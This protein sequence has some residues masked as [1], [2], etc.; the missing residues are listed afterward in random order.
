MKR[1]L[2]NAIREGVSRGI[3]DAI[4]KA[5]QEAVEPKAT[6][7]TGKALEFIDKK[8]GGSLQS[9]RK[10]SS[11]LGAA[12]SALEKSMQGYAEKMSQTTKICPECGRPSSADQTHCPE[13]G[14]KLPEET[15]AQ[16]AQCPACG[17]QN[18][19]R[20]KFC[21]D[22]GTKL[23]ATVREEEQQARR[24]EEELAKWEQLLP[25]FPKWSCGGSELN[26][27]EYDHAVIFS[28]SFSKNNAAAQRAVLEYRELLLEQGFRPAG[29][30][31]SEGQLYK[32]VGALCCH[33]DTE[34]CFEG[35]ADRP[36]IGF[37]YSEP[38]GG[39]HYTKPEP[40]KPANLKDL[41]RR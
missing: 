25:H 9:A 27:E 4:E 11:E 14:C 36:C 32:M 23:P 10:S 39:F 29:Q 3:G 17:K 37:D 5:V 15:L 7:L 31:P 28:V 13:C 40:K 20:S 16:G 38:S 6:E 21:E 12:L 41:F 19:L 33:A 34:N 35:D 26:L 18:D 30:Y 22:C 8:T 2:K 1:F 24:D